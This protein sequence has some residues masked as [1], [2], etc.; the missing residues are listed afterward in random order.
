MFERGVTVDHTTIYRWVQKYAPELDKR[1]RPHLRST[2]DSWRVDETYIK[3]TRQSKYINNTVE[4]DH[5]FI[6]RRV[7]PGLEFGSFNTARRTL[8]G[9]ESM[10][11]IRK[12][13]I[14][15]IDRGDVMGQISFINEIFGVAA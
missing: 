10:S 5:R 1:C 14:K 2:N 11:M 9:Y 8:R 15:N 4:Q 3:V 6:K 13:Q 12:G 7:N